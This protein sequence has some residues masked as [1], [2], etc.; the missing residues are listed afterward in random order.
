MAVLDPIQRD[1]FVQLFP[2][3]P[4]E[5]ADVVMLYA[6]GAAQVEIVGVD[7]SPTRRQ[8]EF[9][10]KK[11]ASCLGLHSIQAIRTVVIARLL[12]SIPPIH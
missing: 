2:E 8:V 7:G 12:L 3:L 9:R 11:A 1:R 5:Y 10:L 6:A 4:T